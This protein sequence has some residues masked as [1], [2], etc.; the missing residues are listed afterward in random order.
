[1]SA[2]PRRTSLQQAIDNLIAELA[3][4]RLSPICRVTV[5]ETNPDHL[6]DLST[7][8]SRLATKIDPLFFEIACEGGLATAADPEGHETY[9]TDA[10]AGNLDYALTRAAEE[11]EEGECLSCADARDHGTLNRVQQL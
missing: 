8:S 7:L 6:R 3:A 4:A 5:D 11:I 2:H 10:I 9:V 1:M